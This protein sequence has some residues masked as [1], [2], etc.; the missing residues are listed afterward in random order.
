MTKPTKTPILT[1]MTAEDALR[2]LCFKARR[3]KEAY[4]LRSIL[5]VLPRIEAQLAL[6]PMDSIE[7]LAF[8][9]SLSEPQ[10]ATLP[11]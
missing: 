10:P 6:K 4:S 1:E 11:R 5:A 2:Y 7:A 9:V 8:H 3:G